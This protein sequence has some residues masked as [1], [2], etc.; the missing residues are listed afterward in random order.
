MGLFFFA[1]FADTIIKYTYMIKLLH[2]MLLAA[3]MMMV[4]PTP[5]KA[6]QNVEI[7][8]WE[9]GTVSIVYTNGSLHIVGA[10]DQVVR[11]YN[12]VGNK[13]YETKIDSNDKRIDLSLPS[14]CYIVKVGNVARKI[15]V[16]R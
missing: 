5:S 3:A 2:T 16:R 7:I 4:L 9:P 13:V 1:I 11:I 10:A 14:N 12:V 15:T 6:N 8:N